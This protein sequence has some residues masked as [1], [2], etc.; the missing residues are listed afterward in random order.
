MSG[1]SGASTLFKA[2]RQVFSGKEND[3]EILWSQFHYNVLEGFKCI[4]DQL[5]VA[6]FSMH[7]QT[8]MTELRG[9][10]SDSEI[11]ARLLAELPQW[12]R[13]PD[14]QEVFHRRHEYHYF[15]RP[16]GTFQTNH[17]YYT[18]RGFMEDTIPRLLKDGLSTSRTA[19]TF[20]DTQRIRIRT[21]G[22]VTLRLD[23]DGH[24]AQVLDV[25]GERAE[26]KKWIHCFDNV[27]TVV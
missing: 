8:W 25:G 18:F 14:V 21:T 10:D 20:Q 24:V 13:Q 23:I 22:I 27:S 15:Y 26:R 7:D 9:L 6:N 4:Y 16:V 5:H 11:S 2:V 1:Q 12:W 17:L 3:S 19:L